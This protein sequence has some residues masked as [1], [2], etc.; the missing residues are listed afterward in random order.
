ME[1][2]IAEELGSQSQDI[3]EVHVLPHI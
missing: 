2:N 3:L 1:D